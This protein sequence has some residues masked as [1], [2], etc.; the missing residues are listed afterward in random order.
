MSPEVEVLTDRW[1]QRRQL[2]LRVGAI[3]AMLGLSALILL[4]ADKVRELGRFGY[5]GVFLISF[6]ANATII[7]PAPGWMVTMV[8][9]TALNPLFVGLA[10]GTGEALGEVTGYLAG[11]SGRA[12]VQHRQRYDWLAGLAQR[13]GLPF[14]AV[15]AFIPNPFFDLAGI[16]AGALGFRLRY[17]LFAVW[18]GKTSRALLL[19]YGGYRLLARWINL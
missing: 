19:T 6:A 13:Y 10:A 18:I 17:F 14:F 4:N 3:F 2:A 15:L 12:I 16:I 1:A 7:L 5:L 11:A 9:A 8:A